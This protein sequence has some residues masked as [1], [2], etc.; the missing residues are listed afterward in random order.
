MKKQLLSIAFVAVASFAL[1]AMAADEV[2]TASVI[3]AKIPEPT[4]VSLLAAGIVAL[5]LARRR[6]R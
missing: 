1:P 6:A 2:R 5:G 3:V 4:T